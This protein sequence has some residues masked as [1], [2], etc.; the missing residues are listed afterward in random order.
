MFHARDTINTLLLSKKNTIFSN[1]F[2]YT[3][4]SKCCL[5]GIDQVTPEV[6]EEWI[7][8]DADLWGI[9]QPYYHLL[10]GRTVYGITDTIDTYAA[11]KLK[12]FLTFIV[13]LF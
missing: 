10:S 13:F 5:E 1:F 11:P 7:N 3:I 2:T 9:F 6:L 8:T 12:G 4:I